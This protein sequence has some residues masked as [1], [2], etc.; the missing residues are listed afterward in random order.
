MGDPRLKSAARELAARMVDWRRDL[1]RHPE[2]GFEEHRTAAFVERELGALGLDVETGVGQTGVI[3][4]MRAEQASSPPVLLR[5]DMDALP[6]QEIGGREYGS[7]VAGKMHA[8]G[9]DGHVAMLL[10]A[11]HLLEQRRGDLSR[12]V[13]FCFQPA[14]EGQGGAQAMLDAGVLE[15]TGASAA[16][17]LHLWSLFP[18][19]T[20]HLRGGPIMAA[21][22]EF[23]ARFVGSGG[24]GALH[25]RAVDPLVAA[26]QGVTALQTVVSR[27]VDPIE[28]AV[29]TVG[30]LQAGTAANVIPGDARI[31][32]TLRSFRAD[33]RQILRDRVQ[34]ILESVARGSGCT[35]E[36]E[37][38]QGFPA[39][40]NDVDATRRAGE[41]AAGVVGAERVVETPPLAAAEDF[42]FFLERVP[43]AFIFVGAGNEQRGIT[44]PHH[45]PEFDI[46]ETALPIGAELLASLALSER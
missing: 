25:H 44:A 32:G 26:A 4:V 15:R 43:G 45:S 37:L 38:T 34:E 7:E 16:Y 41:L 3:G 21:Q 20:V 27:N 29:V 18:V 22:D 2:I 24:H 42:A 5:A 40:V 6:I 17:A 30:V 36:Y 1:H 39:V 23:T 13:V 31:A 33:V 35:L 46:D 8:C 9:H 19:G 14:E 12:D 10:G 28:A 11:A